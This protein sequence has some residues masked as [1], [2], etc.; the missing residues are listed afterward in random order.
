MNIQRF[1]L[2]DLATNS[3]LI[4]DEKIGL[5]A[6]FD[7]PAEAKKILAFIKEK[8]ISLNTFFLPTHTL[9]I[10]WH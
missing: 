9:T 2:G 6:L 7:A 4:F 3:Y 5:A 8:E 1:V 10:L